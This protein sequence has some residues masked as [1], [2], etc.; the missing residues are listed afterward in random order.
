MDRFLRYIAGSLAA[1]LMLC[2]T[3]PMV[4]A[5]EEEIPYVVTV[6]NETN[7]LP[8]GEANTVLQTSDGYIWIGS[9]GGLIRYDGTDF[10]EY[11]PE[12]G[13]VSSSAVRV[14]MEDSEG[15]LWRGTNAAGVFVMENDSFTHIA[16]PSDSSF[17]CIRDIIE[18]RDG[19]IYLDRKLWRTYPL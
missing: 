11:V 18:S 14:L 4:S 15:R 3:A 1:A 17:L 7:G 6:Y 10:R 16:S 9:Y 13:E 12:D 8:T 2:V 5:D 19:R